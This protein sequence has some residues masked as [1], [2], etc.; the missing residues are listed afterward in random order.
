MDA[1]RSILN[2]QTSKQNNDSRHP[3][4]YEVYYSN[5]KDAL[6]NFSLRRKWDTNVVLASTGPNAGISRLDLHSVEEMGEYESLAGID[7]W[8][9]PSDT[10]YGV[11]TSLYEEDQS[12][13]KHV[14]DPIADVYASVVRGN[15][16]ILAIADGCGWGKKPRLAARCA[17]RASIEHILNNTKTFNNRPSSET[18]MNILASAMEAS[19]QCIN[20]HKATLTTLSIAVVC[21]TV[22]GAWGV[23]TLSLGD[24]RVFVYCPRYQ[25]S[26]ETS[27]GSHPLNG[28]RLPRDSGGALGPAIGTL[29]DLENLSFSYVSVT[30]GDFV[31]LTTDGIC[32]NFIPTHSS[33]TIETNT[34]FAIPSHSGKSK[35]DSCCEISYEVHKAIH[36]HHQSLQKNISAPTIA[37]SLV[38]KVFE[39]T[40][41]KRQFRTTNSEIEVLPLQ[42]TEMQKKN[43]VGKLDHATVLSY[44]VG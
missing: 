29:P 12:K 23:F 34:H 28:I 38:N 4:L 36:D 20:E 44:K 14:G 37:L 39:I 6:P 35:T 15:N 7:H 30:P 1:I 3:G 19:Q 10:C 18:I 26:M 25:T 22:K 31:V 32:D 21:E 11:S 41:D 43:V 13:S 8:N 40:E 16:T 24:C 33:L 42:N 27:I 2:L 5:S 9:A 17:V